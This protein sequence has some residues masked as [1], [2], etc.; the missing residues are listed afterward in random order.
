[1]KGWDKLLKASHANLIFDFDDINKHFVLKIWIFK[2]FF[3]IWMNMLTGRWSIQIRQWVICFW[4]NK[5]LKLRSNYHLK[6]RK[7]NRE[8][9]Y[10]F[11]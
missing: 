4:I 11:F 10:F 2:E 7:S 8:V 6:S 5:I 9:I 1:M 3:L